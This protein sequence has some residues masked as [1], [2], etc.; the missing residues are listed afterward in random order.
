M[1][2]DRDTVTIWRGPEARDERLPRERLVEVTCRTIGVD[3]EG[4]YTCPLILEELR[5]SVESEAE[6]I[7]EAFA[8]EHA[9]E[10]WSYIDL[11][12]LERDF[13]GD[14]WAVARFG[15]AIAVNGELEGVGAP[16]PPRGWVET[17]RGG[18]IPDGGEAEIEKESLAYLVAPKLTETLRRRITPEAVHEVLDLLWPEPWGYIVWSSSSGESEVWTSRRG[19]RSFERAEEKESRKTAK[20]KVLRIQE[21]M[22]RREEERRAKIQRGGWPT[23]KEWSPRGRLPGED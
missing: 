12:E 17:D 22:R 1:A 18:R 2:S 14:I 7:L 4:F 10:T 21:E 23:A 8:D 5:E 13:A 16:R 19:L 6:K 9:A 3:E 20:E 11:E 15:D